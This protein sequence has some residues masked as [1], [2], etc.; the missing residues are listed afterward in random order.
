MRIALFHTELSR[1]APGLLFRDIL[2]GAADVAQ[3]A[4]KIA[5]ASPD[6]LV[7]L[8]FDYDLHGVALSAFANAIRAAG[9]PDYA[10][11]FANRP[12]T[13]WPTG[14][15]LDGNGR[16][17]QPRDAQGYGQFSGEG[18]M[19]VLSTLP[20]GE[21]QDFS[22]LIWADLPWATLPDLDGQPF[23]DA[24]TTAALRLSTTGHWVVPVE[25]A[26][27]RYVDLLIFHATP[28]VFDGA[29]DRNG[30]RN[31][32]EI[33]FWLHYLN[34]RPERSHVIVG[35]ANL[36]PTRGDGRQEAIRA[37]LALPQLNDP[38]P[39]IPTV[40]WS[41]LELGLRRVDYVLP[42]ADLRLRDAGVMWA[43]AQDGPTSRHGLVWIDIDVAPLRVSPFIS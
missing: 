16:L 31:A 37:L 11:S 41:D 43:E 30:A 27:A 10:H 34:Q 14:L 2:A 12:N 36:D 33:R 39:D 32:D 8:G 42:T 35:D 9:G 25:L 15:D 13:G 5:R 29:E 4:Q 20:L 38:L 7:L 3:R 26:P 23:Y 17:G 40:D 6:V 22:G 19:A 21:A 28:P 1:K 24:Q 18:G